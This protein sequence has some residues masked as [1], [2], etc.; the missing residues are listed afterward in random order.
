MSWLIDV[1]FEAS[2]LQ[3]CITSSVAFPLLDCRSF[4]RILKSPVIT[5][6]RCSESSESKMLELLPENFSLIYYISGLCHPVEH[7]G[8]NSVF[9]VVYLGD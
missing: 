1:L 9:L 5:K 8:T 2:S 3:N 6:L 4:M 7:N